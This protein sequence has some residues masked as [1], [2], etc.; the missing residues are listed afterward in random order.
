MEQQMKINTLRQVILI[1]AVE[2]LR[3]YTEQGV[4]DKVIADK[5]KRDIRDG[6]NRAKLFGITKPEQILALN[7]ELYDCA[8]WDI[9]NDGEDVVAVADS[10]KMCT[11][12]KDAGLPSPCA[13]FCINPV[14]GVVRGVTGNYKLKVEETLWNGDCCRFRITAE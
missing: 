5:Q 4:L 11:M 1:Q 12:V 8:V 6:A 9:K 3:N 7:S 13:L 10:C 14:D 2:A